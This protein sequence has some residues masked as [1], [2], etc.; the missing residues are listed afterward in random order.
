MKRRRRENEEE[1]KYRSINKSEMKN[2]I[3]KMDDGEPAENTEAE[4]C[5]RRRHLEE[6]PAA[7]A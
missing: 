1:S 7:A 2:E 5:Q 3:M 4:E 6:M